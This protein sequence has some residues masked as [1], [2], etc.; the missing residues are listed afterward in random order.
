M[1]LAG[2]WAGTGG[3]ST[4]PAP[5]FP[6]DDLPVLVCVPR[7]PALPRVLAPVPAE[8]SELGR[9]Y[10]EAHEL[11]WTAPC[12]LAAAAAAVTRYQQATL[13]LSGRR[14]PQ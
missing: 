7:V 9:L 8:D 11:L 4:R 3:T 14:Q 10:D 5:R 13:A 6:R 12:D 1:A 2:S